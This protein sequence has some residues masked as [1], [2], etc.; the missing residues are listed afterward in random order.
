MIW[1]HGLSVLWC[2]WLGDRKGI[3][4]VKKTQW[5]GTGVVSCLEQSADLHTAQLMPLP[6]AV[7][8]FSKIKT[9]FTFWYRL[10]RVVS[11]KR[12]VKLV[13]VC[14]CGIET[15]DIVCLL[16]SNFGF[17]STISKCKAVQIP[18]ASTV[19]RALEQTQLQS[20]QTVMNCKWYLMKN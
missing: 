15:Q 7:S 6:L 4:P 18:L 8:C 3:R 1:R 5:W 11:D 14:V 17:I 20:S 10:T 12:A 19:S 16:A 13:C 2:Y 9:G